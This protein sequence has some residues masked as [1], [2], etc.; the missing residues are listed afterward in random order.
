MFEQLDDCT[1]LLLSLTKASAAG[2]EFGEP[3]WVKRKCVSFSVT[4][5][6]KRKPFGVKVWS[7][8]REMGCIRGFILHVLPYMLLGT[9]WEFRRLLSQ[10]LPRPP[11]R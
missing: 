6:K 9:H 7:V 2:Q 8:P 11:R 10:Q 4:N 5:L 1:I 3:L